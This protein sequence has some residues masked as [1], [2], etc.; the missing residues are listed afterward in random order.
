M[1]EFVEIRDDTPNKESPPPSDTTYDAV[2]EQPLYTGR[3]RKLI[4]IV[5]R[6]ILLSIITLGIYRF[7]GKTKIRRYLWSQVSFRGE[8]LEYTG[9]GTELFLGFLVVMLIL[10]PVL[11]LNSFLQIALQ[12][13]PYIFIVAQILYGLSFFYLI[14]IASYRA[15]RYRLTRT[16]WC[17]IRGGMSGSAIAFANKAFLYTLL[18]IVTLGVMYPKMQLALQKYRIE[19]S[20]FGDVNLKFDAPLAPLMK[21][22]LFSLVCLLILY[23]LMGYFSYK[24]FEAIETKPSQAEMFQLVVGVLIALTLIGILTAVAMV[25]Y[26]AVVIRHFVSATKFENLSATSTMTVGQ[27]LNVYI[28][29][30]LV[31]GGLVVLFALT[32]AMTSGGD[33]ATTFLILLIIALAIFGTLIPIIIFNRFIS[34]F[35]AN[36]IITG[37]FS[38]ARLLQ[39]QQNKPSYGEGLA[40]AL[41]VDAL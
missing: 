14:H 28:P 22:W 34:A 1:S 15:Q 30:Y 16:S 19:N 40:E 18:T 11:L 39:N 37:A 38:A 13:K 9:T 41:E 8:P 26:S 35:C 3:L 25:W 2:N 17:G 7:W 6:N 4:P 32:T 21:S 12:S 20:V 23:G 36:M 10:I 33:D 24:F 31:Y 27:L 29:A 5:L